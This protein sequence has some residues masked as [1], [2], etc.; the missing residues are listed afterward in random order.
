LRFAFLVESI[1]K[2]TLIAAG[3]E[4]RQWVITDSTQAPTLVGRVDNE[5]GD[6]EQLEGNGG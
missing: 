1:A 4:S 6:R 3:Q 5:V 2:A